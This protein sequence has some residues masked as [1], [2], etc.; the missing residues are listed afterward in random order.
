MIYNRLTVFTL[1]GL[2]HGPW[3]VTVPV[4]DGDHNFILLEHYWIVTIS[5]DCLLCKQLCYC[6]YMQVPC[7]V[8][9]N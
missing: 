7:M 9:D 8:Q 6:M 2:G 3:F 4:T 5:L 1:K